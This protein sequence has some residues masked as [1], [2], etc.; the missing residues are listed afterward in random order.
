MGNSTYGARNPMSKLT[1]EDVLSIRRL[2]QEADLSK[3]EIAKKYG[4]TASNVYV[5]VTR[6]TWDFI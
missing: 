1:A 3:V 2:W 6:K 5:I 4:V